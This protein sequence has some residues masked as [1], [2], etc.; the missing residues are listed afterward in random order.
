MHASL[1]VFK[2][3]CVQTAIDKKTELYPSKV[4]ELGLSLDTKFKPLTTTMTTAYGSFFEMDT[5]CIIFVCTFLNPIMGH[6]VKVTERELCV[7]MCR[8]YKHI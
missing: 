1:H 8:A 6:N 2:W 5:A 7:Q 4:F 3:D